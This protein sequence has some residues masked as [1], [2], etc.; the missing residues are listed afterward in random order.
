MTGSEAQV[1]CV[2]VGCAA[3]SEVQ[4]QCVE[5]G[6]QQTQKYRYSVWGQG[7]AA[8]RKVE[9]QIRSFVSLNHRN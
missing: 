4:V 2:W 9:V 6:V 1:Q 3:D 7:P 5:W 8:G